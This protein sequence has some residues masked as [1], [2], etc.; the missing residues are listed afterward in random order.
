MM[1]L[2]ITLAMVVRGFD[3]ED[4]YD[5][6]DRTNGVT[7]DRWFKGER[8]YQIGNGGAHPADRMPCRVAVRE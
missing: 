4:A 7:R 6:W 1:D 5:E 3:F 2:R 8:A